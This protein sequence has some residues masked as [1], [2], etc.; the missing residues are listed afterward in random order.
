LLGPERGVLRRSGYDFGTVVEKVSLLLPLEKDYLT[1][2]GRQKEWGRGKDLIGYW[3]A[4]EWG[5]SKVDLARQ[6]EL[7]PS[8]VGYAVQRGEKIAKYLGYQMTT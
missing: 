4:V 2:K 5:V 3:S 6:L 1:G 7:T 8:A